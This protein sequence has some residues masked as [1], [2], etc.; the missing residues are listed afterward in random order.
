MM[1]QQRWH[2]NDEPPALLVLA[3]AGA[4]AVHKPH[5]TPAL[6]ALDVLLL[7]A[8]GLRVV[9]TQDRMPLLWRDVLWVQ[10]LAADDSGTVTLQ[11]HSQHAQQWRVL[12]LSLSAQDMLGVISAL[13]RSVPRSRWARPNDPPPA[14]YSARLAQQSLQGEVTKGAEVGVYLVGQGLLI[15][16][17]DVVHAKL[18]LKAIRRV[19]AVARGDK[20][21]EGLV[22]L[23]SRYE[24]LLFV[25][26]SYDALAADI[27]QRADCPLE[28]VDAR[29]K[30][31][32]ML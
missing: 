5:E 25:S 32:K 6:V 20:S 26:N 17:A 16:R 3:R 24:T 18:T 12:T 1:R 11:L 22:R 30:V 29:D 21:R 8:G 4:A 7:I 15:L 19:L 27:A 10:P 13:K 9:T 23:Y 28:H 31:N 14:W 2:A